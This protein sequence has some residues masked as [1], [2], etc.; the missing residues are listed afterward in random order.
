MLPK[1]LKVKNKNIWELVKINFLEHFVCKAN[2]VE[3]FKSA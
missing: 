2:Y 1:N 3:F